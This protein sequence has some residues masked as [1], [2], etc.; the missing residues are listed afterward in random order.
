MFLCKTIA[1]QIFFMVFVTLEEREKI[2]HHFF[3][4]YLFLGVKN[5]TKKMDHIHNKK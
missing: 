3:S 2:F 4:F 5:N 1:D